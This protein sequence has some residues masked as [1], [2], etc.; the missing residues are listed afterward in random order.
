MTKDDIL[1]FV[2][3]Y[4]WAILIVIIMAG[5]LWALGVFS[6]EIIDENQKFNKMVAEKYPKCEGNYLISTCVEC[7]RDCE[8]MKLQYSKFNDEEECWCYNKDTKISQ[9]IW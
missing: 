1:E 8:D 2:M 9:R 3:T 6:P 5:A 7:Y 4:G